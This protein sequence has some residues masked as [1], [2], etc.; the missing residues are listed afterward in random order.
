MR[1]LV[2]LCAVCLTGCQASSNVW[3][4]GSANAEALA[5]ARVAPAVEARNGGVVR[6][7]CAECRMTRIGATLVAAN[8]VLEGTYQYRLLDTCRVDA[9]SLPGGYIYITCGLYERLR[10]DDL[11][12]ATLAHEMAHLVHKD[13]FKP[14]SCGLDQALCKEK[15]A[16]ACAVVLLERA[17]IPAGALSALMRVI[18]DVQPDGWANARIASIRA[19]PHRTRR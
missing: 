11:L 15:H 9:L 7:R 12:A 8:P 4:A 10:S 13:H 17:G 16:D 2:L 5:G 1:T 18:D 6:D 3:L 19:T 14:R